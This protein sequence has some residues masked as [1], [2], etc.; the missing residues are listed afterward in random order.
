ML[1]RFRKPA[2]LRL[3]GLEKRF[4]NAIASAMSISLSSQGRSSPCLDRPAAEDHDAAHDRGLRTS[5]PRPHYRRRIRHHRL[6]PHRRALGMVFQN[7]SLFPHKTVSE[8]VAFG[9]R[10]AGWGVRSATR[11]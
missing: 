10:M 8:N 1:N 4:G 2:E 3:E 7:Y 6:P 9:L 5:R 11:P